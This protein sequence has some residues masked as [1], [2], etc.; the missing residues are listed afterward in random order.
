MVLVF[1]FVCLMNITLLQLGNCC[2]YTRRLIKKLAKMII[3]KDRILDIPHFLAILMLH[4]L[5]EE[6]IF[7]VEFKS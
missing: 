5:R 1:F 6:C 2:R 3:L 4:T 7:H